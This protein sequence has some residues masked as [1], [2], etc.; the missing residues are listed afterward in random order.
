MGLG[1]IFAG[2]AAGGSAIAYRDELGDT[3]HDTVYT[4]LDGDGIEEVD[5]KGAFSRT[6]NAIKTAF[7]WSKETANKTVEVIDGTREKAETAAEFIGLKDSPDSEGN[8]FSNI[9]GNL[10]GGNS[11]KGDSILDRVA[12]KFTN[13][14]FNNEGGGFNVNGTLAAGAGIGILAAISKLFGASFFSTALTMML[15]ALPIVNWDMTKQI[16]HSI[17]PNLIDD[18]RENKT[19]EISVPDGVS[20]PTKPDI[21]DKI[22]VPDEYDEFSPM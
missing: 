14:L 15:V 6:S 3:L 4:D 22:L 2:L 9:T 13:T 7:N 8:T 10:L 17:A 16:G 12:K 19:E 20:T 5:L 21:P 11:N 18:P 1:L